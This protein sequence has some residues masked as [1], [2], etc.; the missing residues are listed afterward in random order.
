MK[1]PHCGPQRR[2]PA[3]TSELAPPL[4]MDRCRIGRGTIAAALQLHP[5]DHGIE[6]SSKNIPRLSG[7]QG[8]YDSRQ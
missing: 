4:A 6:A 2:R 5:Q 1:D 7:D 8:S 3:V